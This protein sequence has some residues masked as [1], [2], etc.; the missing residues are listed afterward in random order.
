[1]A[2]TE[3]LVQ[4]E[5][6]DAAK[7][8]ESSEPS[9][10]PEPVETPEPEAPT[11]AA[12][13]STEDPAKAPAKEAGSEPSEHIPAWRLRE[14]S[15]ARRL[16]EDRARQLEARLTEARTH[17]EQQQKQ[18]PKPAPDF[19][20]DPGAAMQAAIEQALA[21]V[22][23]EYQRSVM[24]L[25]RDSAENRHGAEAVSLA[26]SVFM[27]ARNK[28]MLDPA[29]YERVVRAPNRFDA[30]VQWY[31][32]VYALHTVGDDPSAWWEKEFETKMA[33]P[34]FQTKVMEKIRG[35]AATRPAVTKL[36]PSL[37]RSTAAAPSGADR[38]GDLSHESLWASTMK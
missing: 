26:E 33:D 34:D 25:S 16:A 10:A 29:D 4:Q 7:S 1:M 32:R 9:P 8:P 36:P 17:W 37:S 28:R 2:T 6:F 5:L 27:E 30:V 13:P 22:R 3:E 11:E 24:Q 31:K 38:Q 20:Q 35:S 21:P 23:A 12:A 18:T 19:F 15:E 14:E